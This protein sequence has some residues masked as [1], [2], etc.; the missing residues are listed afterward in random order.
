MFQLGVTP[1]IETIIARFKNDEILMQDVA[2]VYDAVPS[3]LNAEQPYVIVGGAEP[4]PWNTMNRVGFEV[5]F[6]VYVVAGRMTETS[7]ARV[8]A[9]MERALY[10]LNNK[11]NEIKVPGWHLAQLQF[12]SGDTPQDADSEG[13]DAII[14]F[15]A[16]IQQNSK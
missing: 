13:F 6:S 2:G 7:P 10:L 5:M 8:H 11:H 9:L 3:D 12:D 14:P 1:L 15:K 16:L 4:T